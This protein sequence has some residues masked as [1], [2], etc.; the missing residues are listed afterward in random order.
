[1]HRIK[2]RISV[3]IPTLNESG[4]IRKVIE[5][6]KSVLSGNRYEIIV[7][8]GH[9]TDDTVRIAKKLGARVIYDSLGKGSALIKG[10]N[11]AKGDILISLDADLSTDPREMW[12][13]IDGIRVGYDV[14][15][16]SRFMAGG[17]SEDI[18]PIRKLGNLSFVFLVNH[19]FGSR[20]SDMCYG[21]RS[22]RKGTMRR[23]GLKEKGFGIETEIS[24][25]SVKNGLKVIEVPSIE[26]KRALG[27]GKLRTFSDGYT[28]L[29]TIIKN[30]GKD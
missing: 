1:M 7:V 11:A 22:F 13:L 30:L 23:L 17:S 20:Y 4:N 28:I 2:E 3:V 29:R 21:Y 24:I 16:G 6:V 19:L 10:L 25:K 18:S 15:M 9:S 5:E 27:E 8:D 12:L 14:C 26:K